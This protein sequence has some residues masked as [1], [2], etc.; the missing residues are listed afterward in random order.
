MAVTQRRFLPWIAAAGGGSLAYEATTAVTT[1]RRSA[2]RLTEN[3]FCVRTVSDGPG[4]P[5][6]T[7]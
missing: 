5:G 6:H 3:W 2:A 7:P 1:W 4:N